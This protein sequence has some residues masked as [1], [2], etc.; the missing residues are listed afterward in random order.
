MLILMVGGQHNNLGARADLLDA[1]GG[2]NAVHTGH[3]QVHQNHVRGVLAGQRHGR[4]PRIRLSHHRYIRL[5]IQKGTHP[6]PHQ[7]VIIDQ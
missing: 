2:L 1:P 5:R 6:L 7:L 4:F 3:H